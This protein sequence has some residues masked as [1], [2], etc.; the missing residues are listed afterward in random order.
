[1]KEGII[2]EHGVEELEVMRS[3]KALRSEGREK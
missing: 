2:N 3:E 1:M